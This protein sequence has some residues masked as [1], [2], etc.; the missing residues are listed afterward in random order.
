MANA[1]PGDPAVIHSVSI[2]LTVGL[3]QLRR[4]RESKQYQYDKLPE[5]LGGLA[6]G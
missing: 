3:V 1:V 2:V 4:F 5:P 6:H